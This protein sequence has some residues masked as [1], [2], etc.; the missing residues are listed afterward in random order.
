MKH[1]PIIF[2]FGESVPVLSMSLSEYYSHKN[3][4]ALKLF[5]LERYNINLN[6]ADCEKKG[7]L[8]LEDIKE[9]SLQIREQIKNSFQQ[10]QQSKHQFIN[11]MKSII[12]K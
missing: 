8:L 1:H 6:Q 9:K 10:L 7:C 4:G 2:A 3:I 11:E 12:I 5:N